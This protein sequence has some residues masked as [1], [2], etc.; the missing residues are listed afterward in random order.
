ME[1]GMKLV[2]NWEGNLIFKQLLCLKRKLELYSWCALLKEKL[3]DTVTDSRR[4]KLMRIRERNKFMQYFWHFSLKSK[5]A[6]CLG[7]NNN[8]HVLLSETW[9]RYLANYWNKFKKKRYPLREPFTYT[10]I[11]SIFLKMFICWTWRRI[12]CLPPPPP[13]FFKTIFL[14]I[15]PSVCIF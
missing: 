5:S 14:T 7:F 1:I 8:S 4:A 12:F 2:K 9:K 11:F 3:D 15:L 6:L 10:R 13:L